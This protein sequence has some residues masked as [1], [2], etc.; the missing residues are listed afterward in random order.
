MYNMTKIHKKHRIYS[1]TFNLIKTQRDI[2]L[3]QTK[4]I[5]R[6]YPVYRKTGQDYYSWIYKNDVH[7]KTSIDHFSIVMRKDYSMIIRY[8]V[9]ME[10][11]NSENN[12]P[13]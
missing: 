9:R 11:Q 5:K 7:F 10:A 3:T 13:Q 4:K 8:I 2:E 12:S 6:K 1:Q